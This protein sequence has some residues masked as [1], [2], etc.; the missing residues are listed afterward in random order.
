MQLLEVKAKT[1]M[2]SHVLFFEP[3]VYSSKTEVFANMLAEYAHATNSSRTRTRWNLGHSLMYFGPASSFEG[4]FGACQPDTINNTTCAK[5]TVCW[6]GGKDTRLSDVLW[7]SIKAGSIGLRV[8]SATAS[9][10]RTIFAAADWA[11]KL[12]A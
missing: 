4:F 5:V 1:F 3:L 7:R 2:E 6:K 8:M 11:K 9:P 12:T 10:S